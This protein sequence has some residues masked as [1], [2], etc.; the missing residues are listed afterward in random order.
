MNFELVY[1]DGEEGCY[2]LIS[3]FDGRYGTR[4]LIMEH[5]AEEII[6]SI[7]L[8][9]GAEASLDNAYLLDT[10]SNLRTIAD[11][12]CFLGTFGPSPDFTPTNMMTIADRAVNVTPTNMMTIADR[13]VNGNVDPVN[14]S[15]S[16]TSFLEQGTDF[17][18]QSEQAPEMPAKVI[19]TFLEWLM[20]H[21]EV[22]SD[23]NGR[24][25]EDVYDVVDSLNL[26][27][28]QDLID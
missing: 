11:N 6:E 27:L 13:A 14:T 4:E 20:S 9:I 23:I 16:E 12:F 24:S 22:V 1:Y 7:R 26:L 3:N 28:P 10:P 19:Q 18:A 15:D 21:A 2:H 8:E 5:Q 25:R 17:P